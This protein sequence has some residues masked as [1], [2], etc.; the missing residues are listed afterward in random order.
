MLVDADA[1]KVMLSRET[2]DRGKGNPSSQSTLGGGRSPG[3]QRRCGMGER[4]G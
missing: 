1:F 4:K 2:P 3:L